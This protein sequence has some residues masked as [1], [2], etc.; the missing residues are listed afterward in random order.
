[1]KIKTLTLLIILSLSIFQFSNALNKK[2]SKRRNSAKAKIIARN[3]QKY[4][5]ET[6]LDSTNFGSVFS[7]SDKEISCYDKKGPLTAFHLFGKFGFFSNLIGFEFNCVDNILVRNERFEFTS[8]RSD[9]KVDIVNKDASPRLLNNVDVDC[10]DRFISSFVLK[11]NAK[12]LYYDAKCVNLGIK[13][14]TCETKNTAEVNP[15]WIG[16]GFDTVSNLDGIPVDS[17]P[18][19]ALVSFKLVEKNKKISYEYKACEIDTASVD[20]INKAPLVISSNQARKNNNDNPDTK[21][22]KLKRRY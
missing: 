16:L 19:K 7:L 12:E 21:L 2:S 1:M 6:K 8:I 17:P 18:N 22:R 4:K 3:S 20:R 14:N 11:N 15:Q 13:P 5:Y 9:N 10:K